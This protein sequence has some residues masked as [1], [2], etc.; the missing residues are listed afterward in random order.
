MHI[1]N[2]LYCHRSY[3]TEENFDKEV[4][5][6][7]FVLFKYNDSWYHFEHSNRQKRGIHEYNSVE[8]AIKEI[9]NGFKER[10][11]IRKLTE[12]DTIPDN[13]TYKEFNQYVNKFDKTKTRKKV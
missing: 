13:L 8:E 1:E 10:G 12:I 9:T 5:M 11:D 7:C 2:K 3:E 6:H 4:R